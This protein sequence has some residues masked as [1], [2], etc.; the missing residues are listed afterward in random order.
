MKIAI[1]VADEKLCLHFGHC[2]Q[3]YLYEVDEEEKQILSTTKL[4]PPP[5][6][7]GVLPRWLSQNQANL[8]IAG[9]MGQSAQ[10]LFKEN[11]IKVWTGAPLDSPKTIVEKYLKGTLVAGDNA[12][13]H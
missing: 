13:D 1:P 2:Q 11:G 4:T 7:P 8:I 3:F 10:R 5:H 6:E 12:C 9:G